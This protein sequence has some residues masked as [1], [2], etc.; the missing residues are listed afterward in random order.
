M[1]A[2]VGVD[3]R[4][5]V[6][7]DAFLVCTLAVALFTSIFLPSTIVPFSCSRALS[8]S[9]ECAKVTNPK[10]LDPLSLNMISE[11]SICPNFCVCFKE[12]KRYL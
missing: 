1:I 8:A 11:S 7:N 12:E 9:K 3:V 10:P 5:E 4:I 2:A 6:G